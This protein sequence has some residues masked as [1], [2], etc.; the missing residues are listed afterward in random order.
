MSGKKDKISSFVV[1]IFF[2]LPFILFFSTWTFFFGFPPPGKKMSG[3]KKLFP[4]LGKE[5]MSGKKIKFPAFFLFPPLGDNRGDFVSAKRIRGAYL[6][7][8]LMR[9]GR[10]ARQRRRT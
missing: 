6:R 5:N 10:C 2:N 3:K 8:G 9:E 4:P 7:R 1:D